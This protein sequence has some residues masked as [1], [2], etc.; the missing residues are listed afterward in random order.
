M[1]AVGH[2]S[3]LYARGL[4][5]TTGPEHLLSLNSG[6]RQ[7]TRVFLCFLK[8]VDFYLNHSYSGYRANSV[9]TMNTHQK[10]QTKAHHH[11]DWTYDQDGQWHYPDSGL[12]L[13]QAGDGRW[14]IE[15]EFGEEYGGF[16]GVLKS[17]DDLDTEPTF[18]LKVEEAAQAAFAMMKQVYPAYRDEQLQDFLSDD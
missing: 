10:F 9:E 16:H 2:R 13:V 12:M 15:Q 8:V 3:S 17:G 7:T 4:P 5:I 1:S 18:Y 6:L 11:L 14:M